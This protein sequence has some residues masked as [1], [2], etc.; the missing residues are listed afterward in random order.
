MKNR[1]TKPSTVCIIS[2]TKF[3]LTKECFYD[4]CIYWDKSNEWWTMIL[5]GNHNVGEN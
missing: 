3:A 5:G 4:Q 2:V 1:K